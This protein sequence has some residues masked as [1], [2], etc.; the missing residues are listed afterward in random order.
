[1]E[2]TCNNYL[3]QFIL[4]ILRDNIFTIVS[5]VIGLIVL[6]IIIKL[7][8]VG[9]GLKSELSDLNKTSVNT[10]IIHMVTNTINLLRNIQRSSWIPFIDLQRAQED[11]SLY[12]SIVKQHGAHSIAKTI[13]KSTDII[14][15]VLREYMEG[16]DKKIRIRGVSEEVS[17][18]IVEQIAKLTEIIN[19]VST[20]K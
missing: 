2:P 15:Y 9:R 3:V 1:M 14:F 7:T 4:V 20:W 10:T 5:M 13:E 8:F 18:D 17:K 16:K 12:S 19:K 11:I 6:G